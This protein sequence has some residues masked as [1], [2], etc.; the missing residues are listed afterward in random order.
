MDGGHTFLLCA[1]GLGDW[2]PYGL[3]E[4]VAGGGGGGQPGGLVAGG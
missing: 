2:G 4:V 1:A 3:V